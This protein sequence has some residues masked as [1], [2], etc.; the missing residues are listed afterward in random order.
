MSIL[1][2]LFGL[3]RLIFCGSILFAGFALSTS[4]GTFKV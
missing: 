2:I 4:I 3:T 1:I